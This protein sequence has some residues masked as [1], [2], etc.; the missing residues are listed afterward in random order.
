MICKNF[1]KKLPSRPLLCYTFLTGRCILMIMYLG[2]SLTRG[3]VG[4]SYI[5][6]MPPEPHKNC[7]LDGD[8]AHGALRRLRLYRKTG[9]YPSVS[10]CVVAIGTNDLLQPHLM[11]LGPVWRLV[12]GWRR[13]WKRWADM[14]E[15][16]RVIRE[17]IDT[18][19]ADGKRVVIMGLPLMQLRGY[20]EGELRERNAL[21]EGLAREY[22][23]PFAD[24][25]SAEL[26]AVPHADRDYNWGRLGLRRA[27]DIITMGLLPF[28]K[29]SFSR[30]RGLELTV[31]GVHFNSFSAGIAA[32]CV[33]EQL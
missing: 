5:K 14:G 2:D 10:V 30:R 7:G 25:L 16:E 31:D 1:L 23:L 4:W 3:L 8:T 18:L 12:F 24:V 15:Y 13:S 32:E 29:D 6:F 21:L 9:W 26:S 27:L 33:R 22:G 11:S 17:I 28:T 19:L 20:P